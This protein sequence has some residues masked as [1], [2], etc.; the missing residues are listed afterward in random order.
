MTVAQ[1]MERL[2]EFPSDIEVLL[3]SEDTRE[4][5]HLEIN[6]NM[7]DNKNVIIQTFM[8]RNILNK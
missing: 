8:N 6:E 4:I 5:A 7:G 3:K 1:L 2:T